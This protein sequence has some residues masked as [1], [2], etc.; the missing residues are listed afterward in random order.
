MNNTI[1]FLAFALLFILMGCGDDDPMPAQ[2]DPDRICLEEHRLV[3]ESGNLRVSSLYGISG[4]VVILNDCEAEI[5]NF[6]YNGLGPAVAIYGANN[7]DFD[8]GMGLTSPIQGQQFNGVTL[9]LTLP[10]GF[11]FDDINSFSVWCFEFDIDFSSVIF[12]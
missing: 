11:T 1:K 7:G 4:T 5:R 12:L 10:E 6:F 2:I 8:N 9:P 3:G